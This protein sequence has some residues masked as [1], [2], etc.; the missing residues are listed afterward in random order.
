MKII[1]KVDSVVRVL[2]TILLTAMVILVLMQVLG[3]TFKLWPV[4]QIE[5]LAR[6]TMIW[7]AL[8][9]SAI[10]ILSH[11]HVNVEIFRNMLPVKARKTVTIVSD[12]I[13]LIFF[14]IIFYHGLTITSRAVTQL[15]TSM[16]WLSMAYIMVIIPL[17]GFIG[18]INSI[19][20]IIQDIKGTD[21]PAAEANEGGE[22]K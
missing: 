20:L 13:V 14:C 6:Y 3:R 19:A 2:A 1:N 7:S 10:G 21:A 11:A 16:P 22:A 5:E 8:L 9:G 17:C 18:A 12:I 15:S 4:A